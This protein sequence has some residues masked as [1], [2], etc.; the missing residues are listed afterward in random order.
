MTIATKMES[1]LLKNTPVVLRTLGKVVQLH[2]R[3]F[4]INIIQV[5]TPTAD[6]R[7]DSKVRPFTTT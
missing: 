3:P 7:Y 2:A 4:R 6:K 5:Y 1:L